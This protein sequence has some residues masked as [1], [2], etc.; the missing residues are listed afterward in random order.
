MRYFRL[1]SLFFVLTI[2][3]SVHAKRIGYY[4]YF[5]NSDKHTYEDANVKVYIQNSEIFVSNKTDNILYVDKQN[6]FAVVNDLYYNMFNNQITTIGSTYT[7]GVSTNLSAINSNLSGITIGGSSGV[8]NQTTTVEKRIIAIPPKVT[9]RVWWFA[10]PFQIMVNIGRIRAYHINPAGLWDRSRYVEP[11][12][13]KY[14][15]LTKGFARTFDLK[16]SPIRLKVLIKYSLTEDMKASKEV[17][18]SENYL[19]AFVADSYKGW[20]NYTAENLPY[21]RSFMAD[22]D[23]YRCWFR[24]K[25]G[26]RIGDWAGWGL[27]IG[28]IIAGVGIIYLGCSYGE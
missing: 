18:T 4:F 24:Y 7:Y 8:Y 3:S 17:S 26:K 19:K 16:T 10:N 9:T 12:T 13:G 15:K 23:N 21:C 1:F 20:Q 6:S 5:D 28:G 22:T 25:E 2:I 11:S 14:I 27:G